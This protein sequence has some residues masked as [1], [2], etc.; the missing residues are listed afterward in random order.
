[1]KLKFGITIIT[2]STCCV[3]GLLYTTINRIGSADYKSE[4]AKKPAKLEAPKNDPSPEPK[5]YSHKKTKPSSGDTKIIEEVAAIESG[6]LG[7]EI[8]S[9]RRDLEEGDI[10]RKLENGVFDEAQAKLAKAKL[11]RLSL[12]SIEGTR[13]KYLSMEPELSDPVYAHRDSLSNIRNLLARY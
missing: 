6:K 9:L 1:M 4:T 10:F 7:E 8:V 3:L 11:E 5:R 12:L 2:L 13:R